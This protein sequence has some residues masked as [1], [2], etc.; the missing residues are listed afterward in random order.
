MRCEIYIDRK[1]LKYIYTQKKLNL[2]Q[3]RWLELMKDYNI[4]IQY[5]LG[6]ANIVVNALIQKTTGK[7]NV[8]ITEQR[9]LQKKMEEL[10]LEVVT[11]G[12]EGLCAAIVVEPTIWEEI[13]LKKMEDLKLKKICDN[14]T[15]EP[16]FEF[17]M[18][19]GVFKI[20][21]R[22]CMPD[23]FDLKQQIM[24]DGYKTK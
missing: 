24:D 23:I 20:W 12:I 22:I 15:T 6:K 17:I 16:N 1:H 2:R 7:L 18:I 10:E 21:N 13:K 4:D 5:H 9:C 11:C 14:L 19:D 8:L 3:Q